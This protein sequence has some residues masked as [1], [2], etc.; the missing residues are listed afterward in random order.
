METS[1]SLSPA[2]KPKPVLVIL[3]TPHIRS[4]LES[5]N[6]E[7]R[8]EFHWFNDQNAPELSGSNVPSARITRKFDALTFVNRAV[9][10]IK[11]HGIEAVV[12][13][14]DFTGF[15]AA[16]ICEEAGLR[17][18]SAESA[19]LCIHK[20]Y[21]RIA[22]PSDLWFEA[23]ELDKDD[24]DW[25]GCV[26]YPCCVKA[27]CMFMSMCVFIVH[28]ED[29]MRDAL[30]S[31]RQ[32]LPPWTSI[33]NSLFEEYIDTEK[34]P[35]A[36][37]E[38]VIAEEAV[39]DGTQHAIEGWADNEGRT[40][41]WFTSDE[42]YF[43]KPKRT[44]EGY[45]IPT[46]VPKNHAKLMEE[47]TLE[48]AENHGL[49]NTFFNV[50]MWC[51]N[52]GEKVTVTEINNRGFPVYHNLYKQIYGTSSVYAALHLAC[53]EYEEVHKLKALV[54]E[55]NS[56][57]VGGLFLVQVHVQE[58][59]IVSNLVN[60]QAVKNLKNRASS[61]Q[62]A[63]VDV[64]ADDGPGVDLTMKEDEL[65]YPLGSCG[66]LVA[67][68]NVLKPTFAEVLMRAEEVRKDIFV[69]QDILPHSREVEYYLGSCGLKGLS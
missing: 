27:P 23:I 30:D 29:E 26:K 24:D 44:V 20:Y 69:R 33:W 41:I 14:Q 59:Q 28:N 10:Y 3:P 4:V 25:L 1:S 2:D 12:Y 36:L 17:G 31:C 56:T 38:M 7:G 15:L 6:K 49:R 22:E 43:S 51:R 32:E 54:T 16:I 61:D 55:R 37:K 57:L 53:G 40:Y 47:K 52:G 42:G 11:D 19:F 8:Y 21:S 63:Q 48:V 66:I 68:F 60:F 62:N 45:F 67:T 34:Y 65:V 35:L 39:L 18:P 64:L 46:Q 9:K 58:P 5:Y 13:F 50:Q